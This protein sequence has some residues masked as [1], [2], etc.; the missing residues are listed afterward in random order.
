MNDKEVLNQNLIELSE[1]EKLYI[2]M[3][4]CMYVLDQLFT[5]IASDPCFLITSTAAL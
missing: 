5:M 2:H 1:R 4:V 3:Y